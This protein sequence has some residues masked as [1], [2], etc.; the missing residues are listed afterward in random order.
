MQPET[1][2]S[3]F[4][5]KT[6][7]FYK[8][9]NT[10]DLPCLEISGVRMHCIDLGVKAS[11]QAMVEQLA[12]LMGT[13]LDTCAGLGYTAAAIALARQ[14]EK[15]FTFEVDP[16]VLEIARQNPFSRDLFGNKKITLQNKDVF[17][18]IKEFPDNFFDRILHDPPRFSLAGELY[19]A[20]FYAQLFRVLKKGGILF[21]YTG[22]P[23]EKKGRDMQAGVIKRLQQAGFTQIKRVPEAQ[24]IRAAKK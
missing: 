20:Q 8:L 22:A 24:G 13:V 14:V 10:Q 16:N 19:G 3:F 9:F 18:A 11:T 21:H 2:V 6:R 23:G 5:E 4:D 17:E 12:P 15:V 1:A 7:K